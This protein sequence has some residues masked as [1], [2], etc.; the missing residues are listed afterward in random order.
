LLVLNAFGLVE[1]WIAA[2]RQHFAKD[3][4]SLLMNQ[5]IAVFFVMIFSFIS[6]RSTRNKK[7][8]ILPNSEQEYD[9]LA[10][11]LSTSPLE[12]GN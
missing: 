10:E 5:V 1:L 8:G 9:N 3:L 4:S 6:L 7:K 12:V 11:I 2:L